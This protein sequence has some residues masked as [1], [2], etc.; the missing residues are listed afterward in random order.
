MIFKRA[1]AKL[2]AQ[3]WW[4][5]SIELLIVILGVFIGTWVANWNQERASKAETHRLLVQMK[6]EVDRIIDFSTN[7]RAYYATSHRFAEV[8]FKGWD[9]DPSVSDQQF[10]IA[11]YQA[12]QIH[13]LS[14][15]PNWSL[16]FGGDQLRNIDDL[17]IRRRLGRLMTFNVE[18][19]NVNNVA[20]PYRAD[21]RAVI[22]DDLQLAIRAACGDRL[23]PNTADLSLPETCDVAL[24]PANAAQAAEELR[25]HPELVG[26]LRSHLGIVAGFVN[27]VIQYEQLARLMKQQLARLK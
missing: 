13:G 27:S 19:L 10:V 21:V 1:V 11:A 22:P 5:I 24:D 12:S 17:D 6:P 20:T 23:N 18:Q 8:A 2:R 26:K 25:A 4:A 15:N 7:T 16:V 9:N 3:D 14:S